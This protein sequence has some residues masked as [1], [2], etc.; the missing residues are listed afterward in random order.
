MICENIDK[1]G[2]GCNLSHTALY[3]R[4]Y[5]SHTHTDKIDDTSHRVEMM[6]KY[7]EVWQNGGPHAAPLLAQ[8]RKRGANCWLI[9]FA[10]WVRY[11]C[12]HMTVD[13]CKA[14][15]C[16]SFVLSKSVCRTSTCAIPIQGIAAGVD[17]IPPQE[18]RVGTPA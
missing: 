2:D 4:Q 8:H 6:R 16:S 3:M 14:G 15:L 9:S 7:D 13:V 5:A 18:K 17:I 10:S 12:R 1:G 11:R